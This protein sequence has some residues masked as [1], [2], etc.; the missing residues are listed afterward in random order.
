M[1]LPSQTV[2]LAALFARQ[3]PFSVAALANSLDVLLTT[4]TFRGVLT[5]NGT[6]KWLGIPFAEPPVGPLR[7]M[8][9]VPI[10]RAAKGIQ[11]ASSFGNACPQPPSALGAP[12]EEDCLFLNVRKRYLPEF[13]PVF[14]TRDRSG[15]RRI[16]P[17]GLVFPCCSGFTYIL[18]FSSIIVL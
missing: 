9:P 14:Y 12:V 16:P 8:A 13:K 5:A 4:G 7:F 2:L 18:F 6:E 11:D 15:G 1:R 10:T 3:R 17:L